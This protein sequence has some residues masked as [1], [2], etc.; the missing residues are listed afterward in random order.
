MSIPAVLVV[1]RA[2]RD[3]GIPIDGVSI[4]TPAD[5]STWKA[6]YQAS[7]TAQ[8][9]SQGDALLQSV[10]LTDPTILAEIK[11]DLSATLITDVMKALTQATYEAIPAPTFATLGAYRQ[12]IMQLYQGLL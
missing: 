2:L 10:S 11:A 9:R 6:F 7:A 4:G 8:Q 3:A 1:E 5:R 12:R